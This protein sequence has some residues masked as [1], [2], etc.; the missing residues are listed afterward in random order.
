M[1][2]RAASKALS[3]GA[4]LPVEVSADRVVIARIA[5]DGTTTNVS[6]EHGTVTAT[7]APKS[8]PELFTQWRTGAKTQKIAFTGKGSVVGSGAEFGDWDKAKARPLPYEIELPLHGV[9]EFKRIIDGEREASPNRVVFVTPE[10][11]EVRW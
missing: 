2:Q 9:F 3:E 5:P 7:P 8:A 6:I 10:V 1:K 4:A 11:H